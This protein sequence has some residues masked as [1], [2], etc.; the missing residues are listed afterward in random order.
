MH[1][2]CRCRCR[3]R[4]RRRRNHYSGD[5]EHHSW[6]EGTD[7]SDEGTG[8]LDEGTGFVLREFEFDGADGYIEFHESELFGHVAADCLDCLGLHV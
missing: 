6:A 7:L 4:C 1:H 3:C 2:G 8:L 5:G